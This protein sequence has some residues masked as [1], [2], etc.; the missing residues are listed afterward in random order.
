MRGAISAKRHDHAS[1][2]VSDT[3][4]VDN[5]AVVHGSD[6][7]VSRNV[8]S[9]AGMGALVY[10]CLHTVASAE[11]QHQ[12]EAAAVSMIACPQLCDLTWQ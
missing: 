2:D 11:Q 9:D 12:A 3:A 7:G 5:A 1:L 8:R 4:H 6:G 10:R